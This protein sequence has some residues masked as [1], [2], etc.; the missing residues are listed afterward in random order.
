MFYKFIAASVF[1][2]YDKI[3]ITDVDVV[4]LGDI[5]KVWE[6][7]VEDDLY[8]SGVQGLWKNDQTWGGD[9]YSANWTEEERKRLSLAGGLLI[10]NLKLMRKDNLVENFVQFALSNKHRLIQP[11]QD[12]INFCCYP[13]KKRMPSNFMVCSYAYDFYPNE[14]EYDK[15]VMYS[16]EEVKYALEN[17]I[18]LHFATH[19]KPWNTPNCTKSEVWYSYL[20][21]T[22]FFK[23][24]MFS[25]Y[26]PPQSDGWSR[27]KW[28]L[29]S[30]KKRLRLSLLLEKLN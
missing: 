5:S 3:I 10:F 15:D 17:P 25:K 27:K 22:P 2:Q 23:E 7:F 28:K 29:F 12:V 30:Y 26:V 11:E 16:A 19:I 18:Q 20:C 14:K 4:W 9:V 21:K 13:L 1:P 6:N 24:F 8:L